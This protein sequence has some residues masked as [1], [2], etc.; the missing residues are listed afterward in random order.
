[1]TGAAGFVGANLVRRLLDERQEVHVIIRKNSDRWRLKDILGKI[2]L[3][4]GSVMDKERMLKIV[5]TAKPCVIYH[6]AA[7]GAYSDQQDREQIIGTNV[8][9]TMNMLGACLHQGF[10]MFVNVGSSSE[11]G[12]KS[13]PSRESDLL[14]PNSYYAVGK[15]S[16]TLLCQWASRVE[17]MPVVTLRLYSV[18]GPYE[19]PSRLVPKLIMS[20]LN[21]TLPPLVSPKTARDFIYIEDVLDVFRAITRK[22]MAGGHVFNVGTGRQR[23]LADVVRG[24]MRE[25]RMTQR[26]V[27]GSMPERSW[28]TNRWVG[29]VGKLKK[30]LGWKPRFTLT[31]GLKAS[32]NWFQDPSHFQMYQDR[33]RS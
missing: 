26:P 8:M 22:P 21:G 27:W 33:L 30:F 19:E 16:A 5:R 9:G 10:D 28:D 14:E 2:H 32:V 15:A 7:Y 17:K 25:T 6:L 3:H 18:Y 29:Q 12:F 4:E 24:V 23:T 20:C 1:V 31:Q 11:Y 13:Q